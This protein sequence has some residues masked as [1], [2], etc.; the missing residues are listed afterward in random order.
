VI[1]LATLAKRTQ[2]YAVSRPAVARCTA[3]QTKSGTRVY[4]TAAPGTMYSD[5][6][7]GFVFLSETAERTATEP[8]V[9]K[10]VLVTLPK[11]TQVEL[12]EN[13]PSNFPE[14]VHVVVA[15]CGLGVVPR[16][17]LK[18]ITT[19]EYSGRRTSCI[20]AL[21]FK[22][23]SS[24][25]A[26][27][28]GFLREL[29]PSLRHMRVNPPVAF[30]EGSVTEDGLAQNSMVESVDGY[31]FT[32]WSFEWMGRLHRLHSIGL[33]C[34]ADQLL[35][36]DSAIRSAFTGEAARSRSPLRALRL[37]VDGPGNSKD[38][39]WKLALPLLSATMSQEL[40]GLRVIEIEFSKDPQLLEEVDQ[41]TGQLPPS[42]PGL[43]M[44]KLTFFVGV[45]YLATAVCCCIGL[46]RHCHDLWILWSQH[47]A[48]C[49][50]L[51]TR[52][53]DH[54]TSTEL[55]VFACI[56]PPNSLHLAAARRQYSL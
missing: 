56:A 14:Q 32:A 12:A 17:Q 54:S 15:G 41:F 51:T 44:S 31:E 30:L 26:A 25:E 20:T 53:R 8:I 45:P 39:N 42:Q 50:H 29:L 28:T 23:F 35:Q 2:V 40:K 7:G 48:C 1:H 33:C 49:D 27:I 9:S 4:P 46:V 24:N 21:R 3:K 16:A 22:S 10:T 11:G 34:T 5:T 52:C 13:D 6:L 18:E 43:A 47:G 37:T 19:Q 55:A 38:A 36:L